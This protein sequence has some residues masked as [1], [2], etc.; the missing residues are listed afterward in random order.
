MKITVLAYGSRGDVQPAVALAA[1]LALR[2]HATSLV[3]PRNFAAFARG[4]GVE[5]HPM[6]IDMV[7]ELRAPETEAL[8]AGGGNPIAFVRWSLQMIR[9]AGGGIASAVLE[10]A[11][12]ADLM[13]ATALMSAFGALL[14]KRLEVPCVHAWWAP[15]LA[16]RDFL[17]AASEAAPPRLPGWANRA[18]FLALEQAMWLAMRPAY[19][20]ACELCGMAPPPFAPPLRRAVARG[21]TLLLAYSEA[22]LP[23][24]REWPANVETT[25][26]WFLDDGANW[27]PPPELERFLV[28][29]PPPIYVG[30][31]SMAL[32]DRD[33]SLDMVLRALAQTGARAVVSAGWGGLARDGLTPS[34]FALDEAPHDWL[35]PRMAAIVHHG[36]AGTTGAALRA[37]RPSVVTPFI[38][39]Q[40]A[41]ARLL[42]TRGL[43]PTPL[44]H[45]RLKA[46]ALAAAI[47]TALS[48]G[49]MRERAVAIGATVRAENGLA[50]AV[51]AIERAAQ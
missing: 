5:F 24:S 34:V 11:E 35:F 22:L 2:G 31:G 27:T 46:D 8:F 21:E 51:A 41:W 33:A 7:E 28:D 6:P 26:W 15:A 29:G 20:P 38:T 4:R 12:G 44:P 30:F 18:L 32:F 37:G 43:A 25:G 23:R 49:A 40:H 9:R 42:F 3:A 19:R 1:A 36:G 50:K 14:A 39:D 48:D 10:G 16:A 17:F 13:V 45:R 47:R